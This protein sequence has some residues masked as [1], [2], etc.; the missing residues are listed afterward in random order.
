MR[1]LRGA[2]K[3]LPEIAAKV[4]DIQPLGAS[5]LPGRSAGEAL[6]EGARLTQGGRIPLIDPDRAGGVLRG[7]VAWI[8]RV[9]FPEIIEADAK[10]RGSGAAFDPI[11]ATNSP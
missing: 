9:R 8:N 11:R 10:V 3:L 7:A 1:C 6:M 2:G 5:G 4:A